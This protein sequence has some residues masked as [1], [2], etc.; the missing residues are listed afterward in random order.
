M[1]KLL[2]LVALVSI[3]LLFFSS[4]AWGELAQEEY[5]VQEVID[6]DTIKL[7]N[8]EIVRYLG[9][10]TPELHWYKG[11]SWVYHPQPF[12]EE[13]KN[14]NSSLVK[15]KKVKLEFDQEK[16]DKRKRLLAYIY[17]DD[18]FINA[19]IL[20]Q[21]YAFLDI[22]VPNVKH[23]KELAEAYQQAKKEKSGLWKEV[24]AEIITPAQVKNF[25]GKI[26]TVE[27]KISKILDKKKIIKLILDGEIMPEFSIIIY[28]NNL[29]LFRKEGVNPEKDYLNKKVRLS[30][31]ISEYKQGYEIIVHHPVEIEIIE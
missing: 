11:G 22:R 14:Y 8:G 15:G 24:S 17:V 29:S 25:S 23:S 20:R 5:L 26:K 9:I 10:D 18:L 16:K 3:F 1:K 6:G 27:G 4:P 21:G 7:A 31:L 30:G 2:G 13:V 19:E 28:K 12:A